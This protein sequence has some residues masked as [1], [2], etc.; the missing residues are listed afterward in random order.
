MRQEHKAGEKMFVD[1]AD[2]T[3]PVYDR[4]TGRAWPAAL[5]V[6]TIGASSYTW[7]EAMRDQQMESWLRG[8]VHAFEYW[9]GLGSYH[10]LPTTTWMDPPSTGD[11]RRWGALL[12]TGWASS[13]GSPSATLQERNFGSRSRDGCKRLIKNV[14]R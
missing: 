7:A 2:A 11:L 6:A 10:V 5:F 12:T 1:W 4:L 14:L 9:G 13:F 8:H 3:L